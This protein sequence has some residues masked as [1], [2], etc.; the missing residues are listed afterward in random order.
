MRKR[1]NVGETEL[2]MSNVKV[3]IR[4]NLSALLFLAVYAVIKVVFL[5]LESFNLES[6]FNLLSVMLPCILLG[7]VLDFI[8]RRNTVLTRGQK[9][10]TQLLPTGVFA[11][12]LVMLM[13]RLAG[14]SYPESYN[15][16]YYIFMTAPFMIASYEK[17]EHKSRMI[18]SLLGT[19]FIIAFYLY[20]TTITTELNKGTGLFIFLLSYFMML[21][22]ASSIRRLPYLGAI[23]GAI[24]T[25]FLWYIYRN[26]LTAEGRLYGWD[27]D[28][29]L[30][31]EYTMLITFIVCIVIRLLA[32]LINNPALLKQ[33]KA[34][35]KL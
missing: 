17:K 24:V 7:I 28:Y 29:L 10:F 20:L 3:F 31:F 11:I 33:E 5:F 35:N 32:T 22:S 16:F 8:V 2:T 4:R 19:A 6:Q 21:Y 23:L 34:E 1:I 25:V 27:Y 9:I 14:R 26:P 12:Y 18:F 13:L 15:Y 30:N